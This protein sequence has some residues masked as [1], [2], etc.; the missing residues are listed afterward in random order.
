[1]ESRWRVMAWPEAEPV[2]FT[3]ELADVI[4]IIHIKEDGQFRDH[5]HQPLLNDAHLVLTRRPHWHARWVKVRVRVRVRIDRAIARDG[6]AVRG[7]RGRGGASRGGTPCDRKTWK[8][9]IGR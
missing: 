1:M 5:L 7:R 4:Q 3:F 6:E 2:S 9:P 8:W